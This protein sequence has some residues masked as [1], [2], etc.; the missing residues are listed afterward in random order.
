MIMDEKSIRMSEFRIPEDF[1]DAIAHGTPVVATSH[2]RP[3][4]VALHPDHYAVVETLVDRLRA[5]K[6]IPIELRLN[7]DDF[8]VLAM[9]NHGTDSVE[10]SK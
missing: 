7:E 5:G 1:R 4:F 2:N 9:K 6:P 8:A 3:M 10:S